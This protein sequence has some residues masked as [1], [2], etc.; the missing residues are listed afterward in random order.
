[1]KVV[2]LLSLSS[3][4]SRQVLRSPVDCDT[5]NEEFNPQTVVTPLQAPA[6]L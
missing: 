1:M 5:A 3:A 4:L 6:P 2:P